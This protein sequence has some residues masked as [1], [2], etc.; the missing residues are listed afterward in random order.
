MQQD[1][2]SKKLI[3]FLYESGVTQKF[4]GYNTLDW[5]LRQALIFEWSAKGGDI[6]TLS[7]RFRAVRIEG[8]KSLK[9]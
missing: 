5:R 8:A 6:E 3:P 2:A 4:D 9:S 1:D 7:G